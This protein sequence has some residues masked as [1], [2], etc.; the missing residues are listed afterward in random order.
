MPANA[1]RYAG[2]VARRDSGPGPDRDRRHGAAA[3]VGAAGPAAAAGSSTAREAGAHGAAG[4]SEWRALAEAAH[5]ETVIERSRFLCDLVP[6]TT[7]E[8]A[9]EVVAAARK[10]HY[11]AR[12]HCS[13]WIL[14]A[15]GGRQRSSDDG[16]PSG[17]AGV[18][19]LGVLQRQR[20]TDVVAVVTRYFGGIL[21][22]AGGLVRA[23][24]GAVA[25]ALA[26][27]RFLALREV[28]TWEI[29]LDHAAAGRAENQLRA[30]AAG[31]EATVGLDYGP[32]GAVG[33]IELP[34]TAG[35]ELEAF[36]AARGWVARPAG[37]RLVKRPIA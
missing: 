35:A 26:E 9:A 24:S 25:A 27:A 22:G 17:T 34:P 10:T 12:H 19:M 5:S 30:W 37:V 29:A 20:V 7:P 28:A 23:Y 3:P 1:A 21:L 33:R 15:D 14:G 18:P 36:A 16:E 6:V 13:A 8:A 32:A 31:R 11:D 4:G 2:P